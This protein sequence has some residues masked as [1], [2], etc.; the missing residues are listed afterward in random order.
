MKNRAL[1]LN[2]LQK[3]EAFGT[4]YT[5]PYILKNYFSHVPLFPYFLIKISHVQ[6]IRQTTTLP[7]YS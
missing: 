2:N 6:T 7:A 4:Y 3:H 5:T 1:H